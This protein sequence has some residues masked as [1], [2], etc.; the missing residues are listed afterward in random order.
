MTTK[1]HKEIPILYSEKQKTKLEDI[2]MYLSVQTQACPYS[3]LAFE[4]IPVCLTLISIICSVFCPFPN[5]CFIILFL[6]LALLF[7][8][9][10]GPHVT[11]CILSE[12]YFK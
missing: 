11:T 9:L 10:H 2:K 6:K 12:K 1:R 5:F 8:L 7:F 3:Q 4:F